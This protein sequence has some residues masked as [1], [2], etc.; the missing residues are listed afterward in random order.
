MQ[1]F[2]SP[3]YVDALV[4]RD[5]S[6]HNNGTLDERLWVQQDANWNVTALVNGSSSVVERYVYDP[7]GQVTYL[8]A[9]WSTISASAYAWIYGFQ[10][11]GLDTATGNNYSR[12]RDSRPALGRFLQGD[13]ARY[14]AGDTNLYRLEADGP[15][16]GTDPS[17]MIDNPSGQEMFWAHVRNVGTIL[18]PG[19]FLYRAYSNPGGIAEDLHTATGGVSTPLIA[20]NPNDGYSRFHWMGNFGTWFR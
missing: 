19:V 20:A 16:N 7:Y 1:Y 17:G 9:S 13:P 11:L 18:N 3:V 14:A 8:N 6:T 2:W 12:E 10:G 4:F 15:T 5:R